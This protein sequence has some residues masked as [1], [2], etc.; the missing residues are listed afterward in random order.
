MTLNNLKLKFNL[1]D[2]EGDGSSDVGGLGAEASAFLD[3]LGGK[4]STSN[5]ANASSNASTNTSTN[6]NS[7]DSGSKPNDVQNP[8]GKDDNANSTESHVDVAEEFAELIGKG[9]KYHDA[10]GKAVANAV[11]Q[12]FKNQADLQSTLDS[13]NDTLAPMYKRYGLE[14]GDIEGLQTAIAGDDDLYAS[15]A[16]RQGLTVEQ[17]RQNLQLQAEAERGRRLAEA[18]ERQQ[19]QNQMYQE[20][21]REA[22]ELKQSFPKFDLGLEIQENPKFANLLDAGVSVSDAFFASHALEILA[23]LEGESAQAAQ[24]DVINTIRRQAQRPV[25]VGVRHNAAVTKR[26]DPAKFTD[27]DMDRI[28]QDVANGKPFVI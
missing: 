2:G 19:N 15:E 21:D 12:R 13:Y 1:F 27:E 25:E 9:G 18:Y 10:Y 4:A 8:V 22:A 5:K 6:V 23:G 11:Q 14:T 28:L 24:D 16:E 17:Y 26:V 3:S 20:W 7:S